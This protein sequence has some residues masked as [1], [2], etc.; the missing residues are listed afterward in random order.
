MRVAEEVLV[1]VPVD[2]PVVE[3][4]QERADRDDEDEER[5]ETFRPSPRPRARRRCRD[6]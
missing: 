5:D 3:G 6:R 4:R 2:E 1:V